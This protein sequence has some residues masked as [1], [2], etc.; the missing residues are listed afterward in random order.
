MYNYVCL[1]FVLNFG[2]NN[3]QTIIYCK[4]QLVSPKNY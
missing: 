2:L 1:Q 4:F 3:P